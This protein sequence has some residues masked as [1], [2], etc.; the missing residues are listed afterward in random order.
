M[1]ELRTA[2]PCLLNAVD[3]ADLQARRA[4]PSAFPPPQLIDFSYLRYCRLLFTLKIISI[5]SARGGYMAATVTLYSAPWCG[6]CRIAK[7]FLDEQHVSYTEINI[8][9]DEAAAQRVEQWNNGS[10]TIPTLDIDGTILTNPT[11]AQLR[12][13]LGL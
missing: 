3:Y 2:V 12:H 8:D 1:T 7:R 10:R 9:E 4:S 11:P 13:V 5:T 6:Y